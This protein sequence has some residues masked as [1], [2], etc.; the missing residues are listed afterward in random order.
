MHPISG[1]TLRGSQGDQSSPILL[2]VSENYTINLRPVSY[3]HLDVYKRQVIICGKVYIYDT[4]VSNMTLTFC[5]YLSETKISNK[6]VKL[7]A[8]LI[9]PVND[10]FNLQWKG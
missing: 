2:K 5:L 7:P 8:Y 9:N 1:V 4:F 6:L 10:K 3:T